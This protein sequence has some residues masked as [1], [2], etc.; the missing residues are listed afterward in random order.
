MPTKIPVAVLEDRFVAHVF[1][2]PETVQASLVVLRND[3]K[4]LEEKLRKLAEDHASGRI[5]NQIF[6]ARKA[7]LRGKLNDKKIAAKNL[8][9]TSFDQTI[10]IERVRASFRD[11]VN[12][13]AVERV[14]IK[15]K[16]ITV[17]IQASYLYEDTVYDLGR[18]SFSLHFE[19]MQMRQ[20]RLRSGLL[21]H[22]GEDEAAQ[23]AYNY[24][25]FCFGANDFLLAELF[26]S[27]RL[28]ELILLAITY[29]SQVNAGHRGWIPGMY[30]VLERRKS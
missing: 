25:G 3:I 8:R 12:H 6:E 13:P 14:H 5:T 27:G 17:I 15:E 10:D 20:Q 22:I 18:W 19:R 30:K 4:V 2:F 7:N 11:I 1:L 23:I 28:D 16:S 24:H 29:M 21:D 9:L 26:R